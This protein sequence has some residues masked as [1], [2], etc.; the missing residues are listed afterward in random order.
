MTF[1]AGRVFVI[2]G[3]IVVGAFSL[4]VDDLN[5]WLYPPIVG[6][7]V[8]GQSVVG[9]SE[10]GQSV[11]GQPDGAA[12]SAEEQ[13]QLSRTADGGAAD[14]AA[15]STNL[16]AH[17]Q[18]PAA[19]G[20]DGDQARSRAQAP[21]QTL[22][23]S[24]VEAT[25]HETAA[26]TEPQVDGGAADAA[27]RAS[28]LAF[29]DHAAPTNRQIAQLDL[30]AA[31]THE[32]QV[33][34]VAHAPAEVP[35]LGPLANVEQPVDGA[36]ADAAARLAAQLN[37]AEA[38]E[39]TATLQPLDHAPAGV[40]GRD[41]VAD[42]GAGVDGAVADAAARANDAEAAE[43]T[44]TLH[45]QH[46]EP[47]ATVTAEA[48]LQPRDGAPAEVPGRGTVANIGAEIDGAVAEAAAR[49][50][51]AAAA[52]QMAALRGLH[53]EPDA[54]KET[55]ARAP[56]QLRD[57]PAA[58]APGQDTVA[59]DAVAQNSVAQDAF[60]SV[61]P[62]TDGGTADAVARSDDLENP[63]DHSLGRRVPLPVKR[64]ILAESAEEPTAR[65]SSRLRRQARAAKYWSRL[66]PNAQPNAQAA[67]ATTPEDVDD[68]LVIPA[69]QAR[70]PRA[71]DRVT[72]RR[73]VAFSEFGD[74]RCTFSVRRRGRAVIYTARCPRAPRHYLGE[75]DPFEED[76]SAGLA[77]GG[78]LESKAPANAFGARAIRSVGA[79]SVGTGGGV[80][81]NESAEAGDSDARL[82]GNRGDGGG[83]GG[84][85]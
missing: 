8:V 85:R 38:V 77:V 51:G 15:R 19:D 20:Q 80:G 37:D 25:R 56:S 72:A 74:P 17:D 35:A 82:S 49:T 13:S 26:N 11:V 21:S 29:Q 69:R 40:T 4:V 68:D 81:A 22:D 30:N 54:Q 63:I 59:Q 60:A 10:V 32:T 53:S 47:D 45:D 76:Q 46:S 3:V 58:E 78:R 7:S 61:D 27:S 31:V 55:T 23:Q 24:P 16:A 84:V 41:A 79:G 73:A 66:M 44:A 75:R 12:R 71:I 67:T 14:A 70:D 62:P 50:N 57:D 2:A 33:V 65:T 6:Q 39:Q 52:V 48:P 64:P 28:H 9:Q 36:S 43:H 1:S 83:D 34:A 5:A 42:A 18:V